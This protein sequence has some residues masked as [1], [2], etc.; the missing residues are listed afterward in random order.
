MADLQKDKVQNI[1]W[2]SLDVEAVTKELKASPDD[3]LTSKQVEARLE[4]F[5]ANKMPESKKRSAFKRLLAQFH[6]VLIYLLIAAAVATALMNH[7]ID[8]IV[9]LAVVIINA[10]IGFIQEGKAE[11]ALAGIKKMLSLEALV[12]RG[13]S[14]EK[15]NA[16]E[17]VPGD[18]VILSSGD[19][20]PADV[21]IIE[22]KNF[23]VEESPLTGES[24]DVKKRTAAVEEDLTLGDRESMA[25]SG[26]LV[27]YGEAKTIVVATGENTELGKIMQVMAD[28]ESITTPF[29]Q[30]INRFGKL[31]AVYILGIGS[32]MFAFGYYFREYSYVELLMATIGLIV[33]AIPEGLPAIMTITLAVGVQRMAGRHAIIRHLPS[34]E[35]LG[36][37]A[38][39]CTDKTGTLTKNEMTVKTVITAE[40]RYEVEGSG[41]R[42]I[43]DIYKDQ[44]KVDIANEPVFEKLVQCVWACNDSQLSKKED[45]EWNLVGTATEGAL[46]TLA[47][48]AGLTGFNPKRVDSIPFESDNKYMATLN[49][50]EDKNYIFL[51]GAPEKVL[52]M[53][54]K[55]LTLSGESEIDQNY[56][57]KQMNAIA[58]EGERLLA[59]AYGEVDPTQDSL[60]QDSLNENL[61]FLGLF[62]IIDP[63]REEVLAAIE[64][65]KEAGIRVI[66]IT[67]DHVVTAQAI[68]QKLGIDDNKEAI[69]GAEIEKLDDAELEKIV[70]K[71]DVFA[72][73]DPVH[74]LRLVQALQENNLS[75]AMT[76]DGVN[77]APALKRADIGIAMG[78]KGTEVAKEASQLILTD[79]N[80]TSIVN[81]V[82]EGRT[83]YDNIRKTILFLLPTNGAQALILIGAILLGITLPITPV[84]ILWVNMVTAVTLA[85]PFAFEPM[86]KHLMQQPPRRQDAPIL[87]AHFTW[88]IF[89]VSILIAGLAAV[90]YWLS[91][92]SENDLDTNRTIAVNILVAGQLFYHFN[93]K[94][95]YESSLSGDLFKNR[96]I[97][98]AIAV[99]AVLQLSFTYAPFMNTLF[100]TAPMTV[101]QWLVPFVVGLVILLVVEAEKYIT[102]KLLSNY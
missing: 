10:L 18:L 42:P 26:T 38:V 15:V 11:E 43:G 19:K 48:K 78:V 83:V 27:T 4:S 69:T 30:K 81:A 68:A 94:K 31:L 100:G 35:T 56:W 62:G 50:Y 9:I 2:Y 77:D 97:F 71:H 98:K 21:R 29:L 89:Y 73:T 47:Y 66:M 65:C 75:C 17:L 13:S 80:F 41:Y 45:G 60:T 8:T 102:R 39:I 70:M 86:E 57:E 85:L 12:I 22:A 58:Q 55:Q 99:L 54:Q 23:R 79:D 51:K 44:E 49:Q 61:V 24:S 20:V 33:A 34:V 74:K 3:G 28:V 7:W 90:G 59:A 25:Y 96:Y 64:E 93:C 82:E 5:G 92:V 6:N 67:G 37:V 16:T 52:A 101:T 32:I 14:K 76:G 36:S 88:R 84:Q 53:C 40:D 46:L 1:K 95:I 91:M 72:R 87:G 63:P